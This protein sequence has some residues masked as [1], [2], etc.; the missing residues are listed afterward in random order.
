MVQRIFS[1]ILQ[2]LSY[3][4]VVIDDHFGLVLWPLFRSSPSNEAPQ[5]MKRIAGYLI[6]EDQV[7]KM[8]KADLRRS[9][10]S[11]TE[12]KDLDFDSLVAELK[13][14][15]S[16]ESPCTTQQALRLLIGMGGDR[17]AAIEKWK[18]ITAW[19]RENHMDEVR[20]E[21]LNHLESEDSENHFPKASEICNKLIAVKPCI[22]RAADGSPVSVW[23]GGSLKTEASDLALA[24]ITAWSRAIFEYKD[25]WISQ[26]SEA[27]KTL[28]GYIQVYDMQDVNLRLLSQASSREVKEKMTCALQAG[29][30]Y[31]EAVSHMYVINASTL[32]SMAWKVSKWPEIS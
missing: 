6:S 13:E 2:T 28:M 30:Y 31:M 3:P 10:S 1:L 21:Q 14:L 26:Q 18:E 19:R 32:F 12:L 29:S 17:K 23:F 25:L 15:C 5:G 27:K 24:D 8:S 9:D 4:P 16:Q 11:E 22:L 20:R 7:P